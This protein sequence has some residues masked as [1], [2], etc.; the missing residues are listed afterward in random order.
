MSC[1]ICL[2]SDN[3]ICPCECSLVCHRKCI[4]MWYDNVDYGKIIRPGNLSCPQC[5]APGKAEFMKIFENDN[6]IKDVLKKI[7]ENSKW[8]HILCPSCY[9]LKKYVQESCIS[10]I[11]TTYSLVCSDCS[12]NVCKT[13]PKCGVSISKD[14]G[15]SHMTCI[16]GTHFCWFCLG[17]FNED[18]I[19][20]HINEKHI[21]NTEHELQYQEYYNLL[22]ADRIT[23]FEVPVRLHTRELILMA[24]KKNRY[25]HNSSIYLDT[26]MCVQMIKN[27]WQ[28]LHN[29]KSCDF[30]AS[31]YVNICK[32]AV[33]TCGSAIEYVDVDAIDFCDYKMLCA[34]AIN[35]VPYIIDSIRYKTPE[36]YQEICLETINN[37]V[38][39]LK[40][41]NIKM[42][43]ID[44]YKQ[45]CFGAVKRD[46]GV[47]SIID[48]SKFENPI[49]IYLASVNTFGRTLQY[50]KI[51][52]LNHGDYL[53]ICLAAIANDSLALQDVKI[54]SLSNTEYF[55]I[56]TQA[57]SQNSTNHYSINK[58][59]LRYV[60][61]EK[62]NL[63][64]YIE[65]CR[66]AVQLL[67][68]ELQYVNY[69]ILELSDYRE[70]CMIAVKYNN[71]SVKYI[72]RI[73]SEDYMKIALECVKDD[74][75]AIEMIRKKQIETNNYK[76]YC[77]STIKKY[78]YILK[79]INRSSLT[80]RD[81]KEICIEAVKHDGIE[82][83][84]VE[85]DEFFNEQDYIDICTSAIENTHLA[86]KFAKKQNLD[87][88]LKMV[89]KDYTMLK[90]VKSEC[91]AHADYLAICWEAM[92]E[93]RNSI[94]YMDQEFL[95][96]DHYRQLN[97]EF[98]RQFKY[99]VFNKN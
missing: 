73:G 16:C 28:N 66:T 2:E 24:I 68:S 65:L 70:I 86:F 44:T 89:K 52:L 43:S 92:K 12:H 91:L 50:V 98:K 58:A 3:L 55:K 20:N 22:E 35:D 53:N 54:D 97:T 90:Y 80:F 83:E 62:L 10:H 75:I 72:S 56:C 36:Q 63:V 8:T 45:L 32:N 17:I 19:Y 47:L 88:C 49:E 87:M 9:S 6:E 29:I 26:E 5:K 4:E 71:E 77:L 84:N 61:S 25:V 93:N 78:G 76:N 1:N 74:P 82:L 64:D 15:C 46:R 31:D 11:N 27:T 69:N 13:C 85:K 33:K 51:N 18:E 38:S 60:K 30:S 95:G 21:A 39:I 99:N 79:K 94:K 14:K 96:L 23:L 48:I 59:C 41:A 57:I 81:Y 40:H 67:H 42:L 37:D 34:I 7:E